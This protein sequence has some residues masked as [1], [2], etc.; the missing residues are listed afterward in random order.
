MEDSEGKNKR[1]YEEK[2]SKQPELIASLS[3]YQERKAKLGIER[4]RTNSQSYLF[5]SLST[6]KERP[7][8]RTNGAQPRFAGLRIMFS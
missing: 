7:N 3:S 2:E 6:K 4:K 8:Q 5:L 1:E